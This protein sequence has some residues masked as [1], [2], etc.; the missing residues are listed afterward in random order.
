[1]SQPVDDKC[2]RCGACLSVCPVYKAELKERF[3][4]RGKNYLL[5]K[6]RIDKKNP[7][8][9][10]TI[11]ACLQCGACTAVCSSGAD[12]RSLIRDERKRHG[13][14]RIL[15]KPVYSLLARRNV[16]SF[17]LK[18]AANLP[19]ASGYDLEGRRA[20]G[21]I[22]KNLLHSGKSL[23]PVAR[24]FLSSPES[25]ILRFADLVEPS[26]RRKDIPRT[27]L[28][29]GCVQ[30]L[31]F[32]E[33]PGK[34]A[35]LAGN[36]VIVPESQACCGLP[37]FSAGADHYAR[38][39]ILRN[40]D[41]FKGRDFE[42]LLTGCASCASMIRKWPTLF[43]EGSDHWHKAVY[44]SE[45]VM[46]FSSFA[47][48][49]LHP[50]NCIT[51]GRTAFQ[52]PCHQ[53]FDLGRAADPVSLLERNLGDGFLHIDIGCCGQG[54]IF[55]FSRPDISGLILDD[56]L[57]FLGHDISCLATTCSGCLLRLKTGLS[58]ANGIGRQVRVCHLVDTMIPDVQD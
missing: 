45:R 51:E 2:V 29:A 54:G 3:S 44:L 17:L 56:V 22:L 39:T 53:R 16:A 7:L 26:A 23:K 8:F 18:A 58:A 50:L 38:K 21:S 24:S 34:M 46:E 30:D 37:A 33:I 55:G 13:F 40:L 11:K 27:A 36:S 5:K 49:F 4:P 28:F 19:A 14:F 35:A 15:P 42:I 6:S 20:E 9:V 31:L 1:M 32:P 25:F 10:E 43:Q 41:A 57:S 52:M 12:V 47:L 48:K